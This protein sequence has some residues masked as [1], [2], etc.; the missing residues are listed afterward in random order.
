M[1]T[2]FGPVTRGQAVYFPLGV[3]DRVS[4]L[5]G[6]T[7]A[8]LLMAGFAENSAS[9]G[10]PVLVRTSGLSTLFAGLTPGVLY[11]VFDGGPP[12]PWTAIPTFRITR[13][14]GGA[15][16]STTILLDKGVVLEK[17]TNMSISPA[18]IDSVT[19]AIVVDT[20]QNAPR[21]GTAGAAINPF[22]ALYK[23]S[24][25]G[26]LFPL[27]GV[28]AHV[29]EFVGVSDAGTYAVAATV[30]YSPPGVPLAAGVTGL[31]PG[32]TWA[33]TTGALV[34]FS[35]ITSLAYTRLVVDAQSATSGVVIDG[36]ITQHP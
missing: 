16:N 2:A 26:N 28:L 32:D 25:S 36:P 21:T 10:E 27:D 22:T 24:V 34:Q 5:D 13:S 20:S 8:V 29:Q 14:V 9:D 30:T 18:G 1:S 33:S 7:N 17:G 4:R 3:A 15:V 12:V 11:F 6:S 23:D 19:G 35:T 31:T